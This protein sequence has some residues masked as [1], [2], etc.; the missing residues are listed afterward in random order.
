MTTIRAVAQVTADVPQR[1]LC[2]R[3]TTLY[4]RPMP[5]REGPHFESFGSSILDVVPRRGDPE[6]RRYLPLRPIR[7]GTAQHRLGN[8]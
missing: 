7:R 8:R 5:L 6:V 2:W 4:L 1:E 3:C